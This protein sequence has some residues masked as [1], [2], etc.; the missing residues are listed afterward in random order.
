M[1]NTGLVYICPVGPGDCELL[2]V[3]PINESVNTGM[4]ACNSA[5]K[6]H[7]ICWS[8]YVYRFL[9]MYVNRAVLLTGL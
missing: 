7:Y 8:T 1:L 9:Y 4:C 6:L 3:G 5:I 2:A